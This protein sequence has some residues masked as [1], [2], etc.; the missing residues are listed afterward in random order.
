MRRRTSAIIA[1]GFAGIVAGCGSSAGGDAAKVDA[2]PTTTNE[3]LSE[4]ARPE[5]PSVQEALAALGVTGIPDIPA[6]ARARVEEERATDPAYQASSHQADTEHGHADT[7]ADD[8][9]ALTPEQQAR[10]DEQLERARAAALRYP[11]VAD[12][13]EAGY[14][15]VGPAAPELGVHFAQFKY[16]A[17]ADFHWDW[18]GVLMYE[19]TDPG[20]RVVGLLY[21]T[22]ARH[23]PEGFVG[24]LDHWHGHLNVCI[25]RNGDAIDIVGVDGDLTDESC[26]AAGG[27]HFGGSGSMLHVWPLEGL[28]PP[29]GPFAESNPLVRVTG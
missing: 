12:A 28:T 8:R 27:V 6:T 3:Y 23:V 1:A 26:R 25:K 24:D 29:G 13:R 16:V 21:M 9:D 7:A 15:P 5:D 22:R 4:Q 20:D 18:P 14:L 10:L 11:T 2:Q 19:G 17:Q